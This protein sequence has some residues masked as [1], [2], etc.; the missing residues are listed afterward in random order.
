MRCS[1]S[2]IQFV[3]LLTF[4][5]IYLNVMHFAS[6]SLISLSALSPPPD[7][8]LNPPVHADTTADPFNTFV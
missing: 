5:M 2:H 3:V 6:F 7:E 1:P 4:G 8:T